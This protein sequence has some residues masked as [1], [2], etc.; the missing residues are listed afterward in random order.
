MFKIKKITLLA[1][2]F[3]MFTSCNTNSKIDK[4]D[5]IGDWATSPDENIVFSITNENIKYFEDDY[6]YN[7]K[8]EQETFSLVDSGHLIASYEIIL[9]TKDSLIWKAEEGNI[10]KLLKRK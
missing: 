6:L 8:I 2:L 10:L 9:L 3:F 5:L 1:S 4:N 7:Y